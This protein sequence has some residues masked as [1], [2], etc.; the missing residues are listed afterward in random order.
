MATTKRIVKDSTGRPA[1]TVSK[2][3][4]NDPM[5]GGPRSYRTVFHAKRNPFD[6]GIEFQTETEAAEWLVEWSEKSSR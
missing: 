1:G 5:I 3:R 4:R 2:V 6:T